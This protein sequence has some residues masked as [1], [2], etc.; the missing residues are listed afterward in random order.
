MEGEPLLVECKHGQGIAACVCKHLL[1]NIEPNIGFV[2]NSDQPGD[3]QAWCTLSEKYFL[4]EG[5]MTEALKK[6]HALKLVCEDC[7]AEIKARYVT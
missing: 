3:L 4:Q 1:E 6:F 7:Y 5:E 2:E